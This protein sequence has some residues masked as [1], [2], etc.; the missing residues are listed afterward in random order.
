MTDLASGTVLH[1]ASECCRP[2]L[3]LFSYDVAHRI[4][5][6]R[7]SDM[8]DIMI[9]LTVLSSSVPVTLLTL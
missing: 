7:T 6:Q 5:Q 9:Q 4:E 8:V 1:A 2:G 3:P